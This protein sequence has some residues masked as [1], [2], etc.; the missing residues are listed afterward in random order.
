MIDRRTCMIGSHSI[1]SR[2]IL[3]GPLRPL[4]ER[5]TTPKKNGGFGGLSLVGPFL[6][7][8][9]AGCTVTTNSD[10]P[11]DHCGLDS[12]VTCTSPAAG[13]SCTGNAHPVDSDASLSCGDG[14]VN[15]GF[16]D[17]CC[18]RVTAT[19]NTCSVDPSIVSCGDTATGYTCSGNVAP[20]SLNSALYCGAG[21]AGPN[22][23]VSYCCST[24]TDISTDCTVDTSLTSCGS[25][26]TGYSCTGGIVPTDTDPSLVCGDGVSGGN[27][28]EAFCC[29]QFDSTTC[30]PDPDVVGCTGDSYGFSCTTAGT[31]PDNEDSSLVCSDPIE[32]NGKFLYCCSQ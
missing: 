12:T 20:D 3:N 23:T 18:S 14:I 2:V 22:G 25:V 30:S 31:T 1:A 4:K 10:T 26:S 11:A 21:A 15:G 24:T 19:Q 13:Y 9:I 5:M 28:T 7:A 32:Q 6:V 16:T 29:I 8:L 27:G 17:Y